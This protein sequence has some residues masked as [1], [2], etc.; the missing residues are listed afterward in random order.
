[1]AFARKGV[2]AAAV[3]VAKDGRVLLMRR[4]YPPHDWVLPGGVAEADESPTETVMREVREETGLA[5]EPERLVGVYYQRDHRAG[6]FLH[7]VFRADLPANQVPAAA[8]TEVAELGM[9]D[10]DALPEP[11]S[12]S[13]RRR[14]LDGLAGTPLLLP[15]TLAPRSGS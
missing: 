15:A 5:M 8:P 3:L 11:M 14:V 4:G 1:M 2:G 7:F 9:F 10:V 12:E 13:T 6:E